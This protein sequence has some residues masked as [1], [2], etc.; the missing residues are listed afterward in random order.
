MNPDKR[1][2]SSNYEYPDPTHMTPAS[3][4]SSATS[5]NSPAFPSTTAQ[6]Y[7]QTTPVGDHRTSP[8]ASYFATGSTG[9]SHHTTPSHVLPLP[10]GLHPPQS[11]PP[12][13]DSGRNH[14][15]IAT[16]PRS[17]GLSVADLLSTTGTTRS[18]TDSSMLN[19]LTRPRRKSHGRH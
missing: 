3:P 1:R 17:G 15:P 5:Y 4:A 11:L 13:F 14:S 2:G 9:S 7:Y 6:P 16:T 19:A 18:S 8:T 10:V 12:G